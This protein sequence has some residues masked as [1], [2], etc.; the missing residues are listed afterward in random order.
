LRLDLLILES[1]GWLQENSEPPD[2]FHWVVLLCND[3]GVN[4]K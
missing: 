4:K 3:C 1:S 2:Y